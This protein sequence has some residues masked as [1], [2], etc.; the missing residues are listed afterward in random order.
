MAL[1][2]GI[3]AGT[4]HLKVGFFTEDGTHACVVRTPAPGDLPALVAAV[5]AGL[6]ACARQAGRGPRAIG[7]AG[8]A[9]TGVPLDR[10]GRPL[11]PLLWWHD[12]RAAAEAAA[13]GRD[14]AALYAAT[15]RWADAKAPLAKWLWLRAHRPEV[16]AAMRWW[17]SVPDAVAYALTGVLRTHATLAA[18]TL[19][20][21]VT[22]RAYHEDLLA[23]AGL[24]PDRL[25]PLAGPT[26]AVGGL[27]ARVPGIPP[28]VPVVIAGHD[29]AVGAW[30]AGVRRP[31]QVA[32]SM[33][34]AEAVM[35]PCGGRPVGAAGL[36]LGVTADPAPDGSGTVLV[37]ALPTS[38]ALLDWLLTLLPSPEPPLPPSETP[39]PLSE[40]SLP[41]PEAALP[42]GETP[43][44]VSAA[45]FPPPETTLT[46]PGTAFPSGETRHLACAA[47]S[48]TAAT[49]PLPGAGQPGAASG[50]PEGGGGAGGRYGRVARWLD[51]VRVP[52]GVVVEPY[53]RGRVAPA[54]DRARR[55]TIS[56][57]GPEHGPGDLLAAAVEGACLH[58]RWITDEV[59]ALAGV[60]PGRVVAFGGQARIPLWM[61]VKAAV[62]PVP[63]DVLR[64]GD[65]VCAG[66]ALVAGQAGGSLDD[67]PVLPAVR[68]PPDPAL[69]YTSQ[70]A[71]F[72]ATARRPGAGPGNGTNTHR[73]EPA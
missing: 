10:A 72:L 29:H 63:L 66:A 52:T 4:T 68:H 58:V 46:R 31:G 27:T 2:A 73:S 8:M 36:A 69:D 37:G 48:G 34:T 41:T 60:V 23:L 11:T 61:R 43:C 39:L 17:A 62:T 47:S 45:A 35:V 33:G 5:L 65:A 70:Y 71:R 18:R 28:G 15:G 67:V 22:E 16:L 42:H 9:E 54:P 3:D 55:V 30:A 6:A 59:A 25:P 57:L 44:P 19:A 13:L 64:T 32:D 20:Y 12:P 21:D 24:R 50:D 14:D 56:G 7:I 49:T 38:G 53:L 51:G 40:A 26:E 1:L